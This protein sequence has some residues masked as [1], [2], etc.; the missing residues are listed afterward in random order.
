MTV[1]LHHD[2]LSKK[3]LV[4]RWHRSADGPIKCTWT[5]AASGS[6]TRPSYLSDFSLEHIS[7][8]ARQVANGRRAFVR[9]AWVTQLLPSVLLGLFLRG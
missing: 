7:A 3:P 2:G 9:I 8:R 1:D 4:C 6:P 5:H